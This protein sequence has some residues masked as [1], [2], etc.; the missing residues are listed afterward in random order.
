[1]YYF[2]GRK[3]KVIPLRVLEN[4]YEFANVFDISSVSDFYHICLNTYFHHYITLICGS[5]NKYT[6]PDL[7]GPRGM[8]PVPVV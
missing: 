5:V 2:N 6:S 4:M 3:R 8:D 7:L 1:M